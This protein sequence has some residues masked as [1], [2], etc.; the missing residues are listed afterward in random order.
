MT[1]HHA[2]YPP[3][4]PPYSQPPQPPEKKQANVV[5]LI[6]LI[7]GVIGFIFACIPGALIIGWIMLPI[8][9]VL[10]LV[11]LFLPRK[12]KWSSITALI[13]SVV[14]TIVGVLVFFFVIVG[15]VDESFG[16]SDSSV[17]ENDA[18]VTDE[19]DGAAGASTVDNG[20]SAPSGDADVAMSEAGARENPAALGT[21]VTG[22]EWEVT[23]VDFNA[24]ANEDVLA[25]NMFN[26][27][28]AEGN[29]YVVATVDVTFLGEASD[30]PSWSLDVE[31]VTESGNVVGGY[32][33][34]AVAPEPTLNE[35]GEMY[36]GASGTGNIVFE[37]P[38]EDSGL[39]RV[40]PG[41][42][43]DHVFVSTK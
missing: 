8:A 9:F 4:Q 40:A 12:T 15:A 14:G 30:D 32:D 38:E 31:Y 3:A 29:K 26:E 36:T 33:N 37:V 21:T 22:D 6:A 42:I 17:V 16:G 34:D 11:G 2:P 13:V 43:A 41:M 1:T 10:S 5:G 19:A 24:D 18:A 25:A 20:G 35:I 27:P 7:V 39:L 28:A 23:V